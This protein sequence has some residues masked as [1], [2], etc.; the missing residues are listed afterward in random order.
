[1]TRLRL[2]TTCLLLGALGPRAQQPPT[3]QPTA[4][5]PQPTPPAL[6]KLT[7]AIAIDRAGE[8]VPAPPA[9]HWLPGGHALATVQTG[10]DHSQQLVRL[11]PG[12]KSQPIAEA[13]KALAALEQPLAADKPALFPSWSWADANTLRLQLD[14]A[15]WHWQPATDKAVRVLSWPAKV[16]SSDGHPV[17]A[18][19][20]ADQRLACVVDH[21]LCV[22]ER[23]GSSRRISWDGSGDIVYGGA[24]H[25]AEF[26][27]DSGLFWSHDGKL[28]AFY[29]EDQR[30]VAPYPYQ[31]LRALPPQPLGGRYPMAGR[32]ASR[33]QVGVFDSAD[34]SL[35]WLESDAAADLYWTNITFAADD[36]T[37]VVAQ[38]NRGQDR[39]QLV[40]FDAHTGRRL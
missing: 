40:R 19:A 30:E 36:K 37:L 14:G 27:I 10:A 25:R 8:L 23:N 22:I 3:P 35:H 1:M 31:D 15:L 13:R 9:A 5:A 2:L 28:L 33:V 12:E 26:G 20:P 29:R 17:L 32:L 39:L 38:I 16:D 18:V 7:Y 4:P 6:P 21:E 34:A 24:A 11:Q